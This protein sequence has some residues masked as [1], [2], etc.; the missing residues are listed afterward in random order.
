MSSGP[1]SCNRAD[2]DIRSMLYTELEVSSP[3]TFQVSNP[4]FVYVHS[5]T[6]KFPKAPKKL[7]YRLGEA[8]WERHKRL[9]STMGSQVASEPTRLFK[10]FTDSGLGSSL[11]RESDYAVSNTS[12]VS[13]LA[14]RQK[15]SFRVPSIPA[16]VMEGKPFWCEFCH[17]RLEHIQNRADWK[18]VFGFQSYRSY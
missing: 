12:Y 3:T 7:V 17:R 10:T 5:I 14:E 2:H 6:D 11:P 1:S 4:A 15:Q 8:N 13:S 18:Y 16:E 9:R